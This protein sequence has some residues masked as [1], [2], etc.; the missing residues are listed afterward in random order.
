MAICTLRKNDA[1]WH[2]LAQRMFI[3][4]AG[5]TRKL[6]SGLVARDSPPPDYESGV[7]HDKW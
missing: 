4:P 7:Q 3:T 6:V 2:A 5:V 1:W